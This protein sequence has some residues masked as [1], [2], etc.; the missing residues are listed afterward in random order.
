[1][2]LDKLQRHEEALVLFD[3]AL[4]IAPDHVEVLCHRAI[5]L[6]SLNRHQEAL[7]G[8]EQALTLAPQHQPAL[9]LRGHALQYL[10]RHHEALASFDQALALDPDQADTLVYRSITLV[11]LSRPEEA[12][13]SLE[14]ALVLDP[15]HP[16]ALQH[17]GVVLDRLGRRNEALAA[18]DEALRSD[19]HNPSVRYNRSLVCLALG[20]LEEGF[21]EME[22]RWDG[23]PLRAHRL[24]SHAPLWLGNAPPAGRSILLHYE[25]GFGDTMQFVRYV[26]LVARLGAEV[27]LCVP[28]ALRSLMASLPG[29]ARLVAEGESWPPVHYYCPLMSLPLALGTTL[30]SIPAEIPYLH[31]DPG[32]SQWWSAT[33]GTSRKPRIGVVW[34]GRQQPPINVKRDMPLQALLPLFELDAEWIS[35]QKEVPEADREA[36]ERLPQLARHGETVSDFADTAALIDN[37][38]LVITIDSA[39]AHLAGALGKPVWIMNRYAACWRWMERRSDTPWYPTARLFRQSSLGDWGSVVEQVCAATARFIGDAAHAASAADPP[40]RRGLRR[41]F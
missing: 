18:L 19:P 17:R 36:L 29:E 7:A 30:A 13:D 23:S 27:I 10:G 34:A 24:K 31:A 21:R 38:D 40:V 22:T 16:G 39:V 3:R 2:A 33:L 4:A 35:L 41:F 37:L 20:R 11:D 15:Q 28:T 5:V 6:E 26:P 9:R 14:R 8:I 32:R 25:Q 1:V 12:L